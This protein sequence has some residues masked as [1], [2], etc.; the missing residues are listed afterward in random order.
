MPLF[1][2]SAT[3]DPVLETRIDGLEHALDTLHGQLEGITLRLE[4]LQP[5]FDEL[6]RATVGHA[7]ISILID[8]RL[9]ACQ[10]ELIMKLA[11][12]EREELARLR[13]NLGHQLEA[14]GAEVR[15][16]L[17]VWQASF[18]A[19]LDLIL[20]KMR[21]D[22]S[23]GLAAAFRGDLGSALRTAAPGATAKAAAPD[24]SCIADFKFVN[25]MS[26]ALPI[27]DD[28][29]RRNFAFL[30]P[31]DERLF[32]GGETST[33]NRAVGEL[34]RDKA[35][36]YMIASENDTNGKT[37]SAYDDRLGTDVPRCNYDSCKY[38]QLHDVLFP[39]G[40][41]YWGGHSCFCDTG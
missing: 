39:K 5:R 28:A 37:L 41:D 18:R 1:N 33:I 20:E 31:G 23:N 8:E 6:C 30:T 19:D 3:A 12:E 34:L 36:Q 38:T 29:T 32:L 26:D 17:E 10:A 7:A 40:S 25:A 14:G 2:R 9:A 24:A 13:L 35:G 15:A 16:D 11:T 22:L 4:V 27:Y 21:V